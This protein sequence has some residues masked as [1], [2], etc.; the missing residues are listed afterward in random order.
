MTNVDWQIRPMRRADLTEVVALEQACGLSSWGV[1]GYETELI[2]P[3]AI[4]LTAVVNQQLAGYFS[5]RVMAAEFELF[6]IAIEPKFRRQG[7]ARLLLTAGL[8][9]LRQR[10]I[11]S[12]FLEVRAAN[13]A[14]RELYQESG[15]I[16]VGRRRNY[17]HNP[18]DDAVLMARTAILLDSPVS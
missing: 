13:V 11:D 12:C 14:A 2:N 7:I 3:A 10:G 4:L 9:E 16:V 15:F 6:S 8:R 5:G 1:T 17:Y 18:D